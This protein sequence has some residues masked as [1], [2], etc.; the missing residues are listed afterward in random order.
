M[1][2]TL[3]YSSPEIMCN[4]AKYENEVDMWSF[5]CTLFYMATGT[6]LFSFSKRSEA[7]DYFLNNELSLKFPNNFDEDLE[8]LI[9]SLVVKN[10]KERLNA[11]K[12]LES[13]FLN[14]K[15]NSKE[16]SPLK[17]LHLES[18]TL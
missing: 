17:T 6:P 1:V 12:V 2:G 3:N 11:T 16:L 18:R 13:S 14:P 8:G 7:V 10:P 9:R 15:S 4:E 5:G